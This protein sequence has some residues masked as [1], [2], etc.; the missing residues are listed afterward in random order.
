MLGLLAGMALAVEGLVVAPE[1]LV[2]VE[3]P[4][5][6]G[7]IARTERASLLAA[8]PEGSV[9][10]RWETLAVPDGW[11]GDGAPDVTG[12]AA[13]HEQGWR[14]QGVRVAV[15]DVQWTL[16]DRLPD[17]LPVHTTADC[18]AHP[19]CE[20]EL[21][22]VAARYPSEQGVHGLACAE[23]VLQVA[24]EAEVSLVRVNGFSTF[25]A[26]VDWAIRHEVDVVSMSLSFFNDSFYDGSGPFAA[27]VE[28]LAA[29]DVQLV[30]SAGNYARQHWKGRWRDHDGDGLLDFGGSNDL[31]VVF[32]GTGRRTLYLNWD[33][34]LAC[35]ASDLDVWVLDPEGYV[36]GRSERTQRPGVEGCDPVERVGV[37]VATEGVHRV[38]VRA[39]RVA[40]AWLDVDLLVL[41]GQVVEP[42]AEGSIVDP[43]AHE[44]AF[45]VGAVDAWGYLRNRAESFSSRG[46]TNG[47]LAKPDVAGPDGLSVGTYGVRGF[48]GTSAATPAVAGTMALV[49]S[50]EPELRPAEAAERLRA[51]ALG[52]E[53]GLDDPALGAGRVRL[54]APGAEAL[55]CVGPPRDRALLF[56]PLLAL[57]RRRPTRARE[58]AAAPPAACRSPAAPRG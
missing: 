43:G 38:V 17:D 32:N 52:D 15:F 7:A 23:T 13:W 28:R 31:P 53:V 45:T 51:W 11:P 21:D 35:G 10:W 18:W 14:G 8:P 37:E 44:L 24:P 29:A 48:F 4:A 20:V 55:G 30:T 26:A 1:D 19:S 33:E 27:L 2:R 57:G 47:G 56:L 12:A 41:G 40:P 54:P 49:L 36:V 58:A 34:H 46:P 6:P 16:G 9:A 42:V 39:E 3:D 5:W 50:R 25:E 22:L